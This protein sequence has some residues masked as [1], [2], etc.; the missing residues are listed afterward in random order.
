MKTH[1]ESVVVEVCDGA[2]T[3]RGE[4]TPYPRYGET[5]DSVADQLQPLVQAYRDGAGLSE[6]VRALP[7]G[8]ARNALDCAA[9]DLEARATGRSVSQM[10]NRPPPPVMDSAVTISLDTVAA[11][12][13]AAEA[14]ADAPVVKV[15]LDASDPASRLAAVAAAAPKAKL[16]VDPN[17]SWTA[18]ILR[19][20][21][22]MLERLNVAFVEQPLPADEDEALRGLTSPVPICADESVHTAEDLPGLAGK[23][24]IV[25]IKLDKTG[26]LTDALVLLEQARARGFGVMSGCMVASSWAIAPAMIIAAQADW[27]DLDGPWWIAEDRPG[28]CRFEHGRLHPPSPGFWG[29]P[30]PADAG[31]HDGDERGQANG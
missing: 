5:L 26:G 9:W 15:K 2:H 10:L 19:Q 17:E 29:D 31:A 12:H 6:L 27:V 30:E 20:M 8:A 13:A 11:M 23:Y 7:H 24:Q 21:A 22:P 25:N 1:A 14:A 18:E 3:G 4:C 28:G 16:I